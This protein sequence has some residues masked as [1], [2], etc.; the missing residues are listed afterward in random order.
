[1]LGQKTTDFLSHRLYCT[2]Q[3]AFG[4]LSGFT[5]ADIPP[6]YNPFFLIVY[7]L[8]KFPTSYSVI[9]F[10]CINPIVLLLYNIIFTG[11]LK[12]TNEIYVHK[13]QK[14]LRTLRIHRIII[15]LIYLL[16]FLYLLFIIYCFSYGFRLWLRCVL[17]SRLP[18]IPVL[19]NSELAR[20]G[21]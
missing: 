20:P 3:F 12:L 10:L 9:M 5:E 16:M 6:F 4:E 8:V 11:T 15:V 14:K 19:K 18:V 7:M 1:L 13:K 17:F 2:Y 21:I